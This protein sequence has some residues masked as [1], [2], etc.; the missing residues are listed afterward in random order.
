MLNPQVK[1][2]AGEE[3]GDRFGRFVVISAGVIIYQALDVLG[4]PN[5]SAKI[6][7]KGTARGEASGGIDILEDE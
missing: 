4:Q 7:F 3:I 5:G 6:I 2:S 1:C